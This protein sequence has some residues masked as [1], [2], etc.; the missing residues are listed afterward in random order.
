MMHVTPVNS[1][2][3]TSVGY[4]SAKRILL[5]EYT[6]GRTYHYLKVPPDIYEDLMSADSIGEFVNLEIKPHYDCDEVG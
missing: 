5:L 2:A 6:N 4:D 1:S 3:I